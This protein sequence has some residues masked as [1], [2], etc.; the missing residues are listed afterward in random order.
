MT[1]H[2]DV[3]VIGGGIAGISAA[4]NLVSAA[5]VTVL[6]MEPQIGF[7]STG[8]SA[9][10]FILNYGNA[11]LRALNRLAYPGLQ[12]EAIGETVLS[13]RGLLLVAGNDD[14]DSYRS[15]LEGAEGLVQMNGTEAQTLVPALRADRV[16]AGLYE[17][18]AQEIDVDRLL[19]GYAR[20]VRSQG[21]TIETAQRVTAITRV[22]AD[23]QVTT[24][25]ETYMAG[26]VINAAGAW[27]DQVAIM[28][29][30]E[31]IG[32]QPMRRSAVLMPVPKSVGSLRDW[33]L[34]G[35]VSETWYAKP[36]GDVLM[37]SPADEDPVPPQ[38]VYP[39]DMVLAEGLDRFSQMV[40]I[41]L[42][43]PTH[44][45]A[46][47]RSFVPDRTPVVGP[48]PQASGFFWLAGQ[49][50]YGIQTAPALAQIV[51]AACLKSQGNFP[52]EVAA[53]VSPARLKRHAKT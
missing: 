22:G 40:D 15:Y 1:Y 23:W 35:S 32:L 25:T 9:A 11:T 30:I 48:D 10:I 51:S 13:P 14:M 6:E 16:A 45:W 44:N 43:R 2:C 41:P 20:Q 24:D 18:D 53:A 42:A 17:K 38:D 33:P 46:G 37:I 26:A 47:L 39:D 36:S 3:L 50:G 12:G 34:F 27:A 4:A 31:P 5:K 21:G 28:A 19:Q 29:G 52:D 8:R 49:G 7:H